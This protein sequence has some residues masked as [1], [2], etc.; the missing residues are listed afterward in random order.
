M[1][2]WVQ[3]ALLFLSCRTT[4]QL[5]LRRHK[6]KKE[7]IGI[8][9]HLGIIRNQSIFRWIWSYCLEGEIRENKC[10]NGF[11]INRSTG[12]TS[13]ESYIVMI[14]SNIQYI[15]ISSTRFDIRWYYHERRKIIKSPISLCNFKSLV[16]LSGSNELL[17]IRH[18]YHWIER[19]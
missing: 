19:L 17:L 7:C 15:N 12:E 4:N 2:Q 6:K 16:F 11:L 18:L 14:M 5:F 8:R 13:E 9:I 3:N 10:D 1:N